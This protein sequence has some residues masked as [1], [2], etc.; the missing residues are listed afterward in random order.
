M[1][2]MEFHCVKRIMH[3]LACYKDVPGKNVSPAKAFQK[4]TLP[5]TSTLMS[6]IVKFTWQFMQT[7]KALS[8][9]AQ[10]VY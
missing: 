3:H 4:V 2:G 1:G 8:L 6:D 10:T 7:S 9:T 5:F